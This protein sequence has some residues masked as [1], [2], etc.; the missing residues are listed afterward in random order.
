MLHSRKPMVHATT[1]LLILVLS[2]SCA[3]IWLTNSA[4]MSG[5]ARQTTLAQADSSSIR[6]ITLPTNDLVYDKNTG[7][8]YASV[9]SAA[10]AGGNSITPV[11]P[12][13]GTVGASVL[14][15]SEPTKLALSDNGQYLYAFLDGASAIRRLDVATQTPGLQF[16]LGQQDP[17][18]GNYSVTD[19]AVAPGSPDVVAVARSYRGTSPPEAGVAIFDNGVQRSKTGPGHSD[20]SDFLAFSASASKLYGGGYYG[21]LRTMTIDSSGVAATSMTSFTTGARIKFDNGLVYSATGQVINPDSGTILGTFSGVTSNNFV[22]DS[23]VGR[24][25]YLLGNQFGGSNSTLTLK[26]FDVNTFLPV[27]ALTISGVNGDVTSLVRWGANGLAFRTSG[28]QLFLIQTSLIPS[29]EPIPTP[30]AT[31]APT[32]TPSPSPVDA[33]VRQLSLTTN[34]MV[35]SQATQMLYTS[36][37]S[38]AGAGGNSITPINPVDGAIGKSVFIGSEPTKLALSDDGQSLYAGLDGAGAVRRFDVSSQTPGLQFSL[39]LDNFYGSY[40]ISD[41]VVAPGNP[42]L[43][44]V[45]RNYRG[46]SPPEAGVAI[47]DNGVQRSKAGPGHIAGSDFLAFSASPA[48]LYGATYSGLSTMTVDDAGVT[49]ASTVPFSSGYNIKFSNGLVYGAFGQVI[50]PETGALVGTFTIPSGI[51][52]YISVVIPDSA[53]GRVF[54]LVSQGANVQLRAYDINT[55]LPIGSLTISGVNGTVSSL[56]RWGANGLAFRTSSNQIF[57]VQTSL[58]NSSVPVPTTSPTP[59]PSPT[60]KPAP[61]YVPT[62]VRQL[63]L[64]ANDLVYH[65]GT[66]SLYASVPSRAGSGGNSITPVNP[67]NGAIGASVFVGSEPNKLALADDGKT[68]Y[69]SLDGA[70]AIRRFDLATQTPGLQ[71]S[72]LNGFQRPA[73]MAVVPGNPQSLAIAGGFAGVAIYDNGV[74]RPDTSKNNAYSVD[75][76]EFSDSPTV[77]Y[78]YDNQSSGFELVKLAVVSSG[79]KGVSTAQNLVSG[80][81]IDIKFVNGLLYSTSGRVVNPETKQIIGTFTSQ[82]NTYNSA[83]AMAVDVA[84]G[85]IFFLSS[86]GSSV[87]LSAYDINTFLPVGAVTLAGINGTPSSLVRWGANGLAFRLAPTFG[88]S[89][90]DSKVYLVQTALV[91]ATSPIPTGMQFSATNYFAYEGSGSIDVTVNRTGDIS[92]PS[93]VNF[94]TTNGTAT[95]RSDYTTAS[96]T[97]SFAAGETSKTFTVLITDN[98]YVDG[99]RTIN[100]TLGNATG[101][102]VNAPNKATVTIQDNDFG[103]QTTNPIDFAQSFVRQQYSDFLNRVPDTG[104]LNYWTALITKCAS[105]DAKCLNTQRVSVSAAFFIEQEFQDTGSFVYRFYKASYGQPPTYAQFMPDRSRVVGGANLEAGKQA[106]ADAWVQRPDFLA[107]YPQ[108]GTPFI[109][110]L[111]QTIQQG[112][113]VDLSSQRNAFIADFNA[114]QSRARIVRQ[115]AENQAFQQ[116]EY[117]RAFVLMQYFGY[118]RRDPDTAGYQFWLDILSNRVPNNYRSMVCAFVT[119]REYQE[120]FSSIVTRN[121]SVC[122]NI[123]Q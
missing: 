98:A 23:S 15:G 58:V 85:R 22:T 95:E 108:T 38:A 69:V 12:A 78:G 31:P 5:R 107:K 73:D 49:V 4:Y 79:V 75:R 1:R 76:I 94:L 77:L 81:G 63:D 13:T 18:H 90:T 118:L 10:G 17:F 114:N 33:F 62:Y 61:A 110:A 30:A 84:L 92:V 37:P 87:L 115:A 104:G 39:G 2:L 45:A 121:D 117:N 8:I 56:V 106:F 112:S 86:N 111:L 122:G 25:Y 59:T 83:S 97:L 54:F 11:D 66:Q 6:Q 64:P 21:G 67:V 102:L 89:S 28:N 29:S 34:D 36:V 42:N 40:A 26:A 72:P 14:I 46:I 82:G 105:N 101:A 123:G 32:P 91:S 3:T 47:F 68:M 116:A 43:V 109:D 50:N 52:S 55:F 7:K 41:M 74:Q 93:T 51:G 65:E 27:G 103:T 71:F 113:G 96:G 16:G 80:Y 20:G 19:I 119:S 120:R 100:L 57:L 35:Y 99:N 9:P 88:S 44:A 60:P 53:N 70:S 24:A 48:K